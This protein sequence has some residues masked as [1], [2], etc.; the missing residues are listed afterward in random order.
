MDKKSDIESLILLWKFL[1]TQRKK[2]L[3]F[4]LLLMISTS[5][6]ESF[7]IGAI[8]P[9]LSIL[10]S[11]EKIFSHSFAISFIQ[12]FGISSSDQL[13]LPF[14]IFFLAAIFFS[15]LLRYLLLA[16]TISFSYSVGADFSYLI[17]RATLYQSY[18]RHI[19]M[20]SGQVVNG[21]ISQAG[22]VINNAI[23]PTLMLLSAGFLFIAIFLP[24]LI[25]NTLV[26]CLV[27]GGFAF[28]YLVIIVCTR[29]KLQKNSRIVSEQSYLVLKSLNEG[30]GGVREIL[31]N[32]SQEVFLKNFKNADKAW[33][34]AQASNSIISSF[35]RYG[36]E[37]FAM[38]LIIGLAYFLFQ[39]GNASAEVIP[40]L[41]TL[42]FGAQRLLPVIQ[43]AYASWSS[44]VGVQSTIKDVLILIN[45][46]LEPRES[47]FS[48][49]KIF[50]TDTI[51]LRDIWFRYNIDS[52]WV[53][54]GLSLN[55][56]KGER[57]GF[58]GVTGSGKSTL[59]DLVMGLL[60]PS[61]GF[62]K[63]DGLEISALN[64]SHW[65]ENIAHVSQAIFLSDD[66][67]AQNI[68]FGVP[69]DLINI[70]KVKAAAKYAQI[71]SSIESMDQQY[72]TIV[73]ERGVKLSGGQRQR[74]GIARALY[75]EASILVLDEATSALDMET[76]QD[77]VRAIESL[78]RDL[79]V[80]VIAH[81]LSTLKSCDRIVELKNG[82]LN[83]KVPSDPI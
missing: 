9:F 29:K 42:A 6:V 82:K 38:L 4:L 21:V 17:Y 30:L 79:T 47:L 19:S 55:I 57:I 14:T 31:M 15:G 64:V 70:N 50:F 23:L 60:S 41:G 61:K 10:T 18:E 36:I 68:A 76:E 27:F 74:I 35:P 34:S 72:S 73:G 83:E 44:I 56:K 49:N 62:L 78:S 12:L 22:S 2:Q 20:N 39:G 32:S 40:L 43:Q 25:L 58:V 51:V 11:P 80:L 5:F 45:K 24:L 65:R 46:S 54:K 59:L 33:R 81:R 77:L 1:S 67:I 28:I 37:V 75:K 52:L 7:A 71:S 8:L 63:V 26:T 16:K 69:P 13:L 66:T 53:L 3:I 48:E